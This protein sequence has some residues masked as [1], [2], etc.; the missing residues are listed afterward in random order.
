M[1][2]RAPKFPTHDPKRDGNVFAWIV[3]VTPEIRRQRQRA[4]A[5]EFAGLSDHQRTRVS[6]LQRLEDEH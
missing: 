5:A 1:S 4:R 6:P 3:R 2:T